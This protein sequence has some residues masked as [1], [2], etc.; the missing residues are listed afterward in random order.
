MQHSTEKRSFMGGH[1]TIERFKRLSPFQN[2]KPLQNC[3]RSLF[4]PTQKNYNALQE[5]SD[6]S[7]D[8]KP[9][10]KHSYSCFST[11]TISTFNVTC[12]EKKKHKTTSSAQ[13][14]K[15]FVNLLHGRC[16]VP[17]GQSTRVTSRKSTTVCLNTIV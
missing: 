15:D 11:K 6:H 4:S 2:E 10:G 7:C 14:A 13:S 3:K 8:H 5:D 16:R 17:P 9:L 1:K 12:S